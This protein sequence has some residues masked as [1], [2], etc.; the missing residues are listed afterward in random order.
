MSPYFTSPHSILLCNNTD[1]SKELRELAAGII[2]SNP[3]RFNTALLGKSNDEYTRWLLREESWGGV[4]VCVCVCEREREGH[5]TRKCVIFPSL[6]G[7]EVIV[8]SE[9]FKVE[10]D[11]VDIQTQRVDRFGIMY[12]VLCT[13]QQPL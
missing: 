11:V 10:L 4:C 9:H 6:G 2:V 13:V 1:T 3:D 8:F 7:I 5:C 12:S